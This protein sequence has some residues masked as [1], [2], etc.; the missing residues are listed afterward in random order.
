M[1][2]IAKDPWTWEQGTNKELPSAEKVENKWLET[3]G[4]LVEVEM[5]RALSQNSRQTEVGHKETQNG[6]PRK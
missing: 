3:G 6:Y 2:F 5:G 4:L 1:G